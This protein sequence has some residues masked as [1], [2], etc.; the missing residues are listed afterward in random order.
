M[1]WSWSV[2]NFWIR[3]NRSI[4]ILRRR[5]VL[6][7]KSESHLDHL[8]ISHFEV[9][10]LP[11]ASYIWSHKR[12][13][14]SYWSRRFLLCFFILILFVPSGLIFELLRQFVVFCRSPMMPSVMTTLVHDLPC[15]YSCLSALSDYERAKPK[16]GKAG[17]HFGNFG[18]SRIQAEGRGNTHPPFFWRELDRVVYQLM[19]RLLHT[20]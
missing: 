19:S 14:T 5:E 9:F 2:D 13:R 17:F 15:T 8:T 10:V 6:K 3:S 1:L 12:P 18:A 16:L 4:L 11:A 7:R 20:R